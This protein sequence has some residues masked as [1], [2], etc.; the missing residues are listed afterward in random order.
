[1]CNIDDTDSYIFFFVE[2]NSVAEIRI[3][4]GD[5]LLDFATGEMWFDEE[6]LFGRNTEYYRCNKKLEYAT[7]EGSKEL[8]LD[9]KVDLRV[10]SDFGENFYSIEERQF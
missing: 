4:D 9:Y 7:L 10:K 6:I 2:R 3:R 8:N 1:M 5:Y